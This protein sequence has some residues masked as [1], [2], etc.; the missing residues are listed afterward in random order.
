MNKKIMRYAS[1][2]AEYNRATISWDGKTYWLYDFPSWIGAVWVIDRENNLKF[3][4]SGT[5]DGYVFFE[6][7]L[8]GHVIMSHWPTSVDELHVMR[9][10]LLDIAGVRTRYP[11]TEALFTEIYEKACLNATNEKARDHI[12]RYGPVEAAKAGWKIYDENGEP[13]YD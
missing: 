13:K 4:G 11:E 8:M 5:C 1:D 3:D 7:K 12:K 6:G 2:I 9:N 10:L